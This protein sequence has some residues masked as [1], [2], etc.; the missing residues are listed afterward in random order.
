[1]FTPRHRSLVARV[2]LLSGLVSASGMIGCVGQE[3]YDNVHGLADSAVNRRN[4]AVRERDEAMARLRALEAQ[5]LRDQQALA[6]LQRQNADLLRAL[7]DAGITL[8]GLQADL[9]NL[10]LSALDPQT[11][12][13]LRELADAYP[14][15]IS[16]DPAKGMLRFNSDLTFNSGDDTVRPEARQSLAA[17]ARVLENPVAQAY[18][19]IIV[20]HTDAQPI[21][22]SINRFPTNVHLSA[23]R[24]IAV[25]RALADQGAEPGKMQIA[26]WGE[27]RPAVPNN[28]PSGNTPQNRRVEIYLTRHRADGDAGAAAYSGTPATRDAAPS[29]RT[30]PNRPVDLVK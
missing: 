6:E 13:L 12:R 16:Y 26:G 24:A 8:A 18:D 19:L 3:D 28:M 1:M 23:F 15:L 14:D 17:L 20:G 27:F 30:T 11:D 5:S 21:G 4:Q 2:L 9:S 10:K 7:N 29:P 22:R 25:R